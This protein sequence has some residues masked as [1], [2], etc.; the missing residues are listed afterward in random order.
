MPRQPVVSVLIVAQRGE[1]T[2][3]RAIRRP[4]AQAYTPCQAIVLDDGPDDLTAL[5]RAGIC[6]DRLQPGRA[7]WG[8]AE[9][10][11]LS[12]EPARAA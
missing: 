5:A 9:L 1:A 8:E 7:P 3:P 10:A 6:A 2:R 4:L 12:K 11:C